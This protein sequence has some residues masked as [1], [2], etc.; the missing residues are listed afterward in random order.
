MEDYIVYYLRNPVSPNQ[1][2]PEGMKKRFPKGPPQV[3]VVFGQTEGIWVRG[4]ALC[5]YSEAPS[6]VGGRKEA[7]KYFRRAV[8]TKKDNFPVIRDK[9]KKIAKDVFYA[10]GNKDNIFPL[11]QNKFFSAHAQY[12]TKPTVLEVHLWERTHVKK[13][14]VVEA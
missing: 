12:N 9:A 2:S 11:T 4:V 10:P 14:E 8:G 3:T 5:S 1:V 6:K 13:E 7:L